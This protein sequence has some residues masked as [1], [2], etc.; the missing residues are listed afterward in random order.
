MY[1]HVIQYTVGPAY[2]IT[3]WPIFKASFSFHKI[4]PKT[5][6]LPYILICHCT[7]LPPWFIILDKN[8]FV[9]VSHH[10][11]IPIW[12]AMYGM[13]E[14]RYEESFF[15][16]KYSRRLKRDPQ[17]FIFPYKQISGR[18]GDHKWCRM[19]NAFILC[20]LLWVS[21]KSNSEQR[22]WQ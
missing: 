18:N 16:R 14:W 2:Q 15:L 11:W 8:N 20:D 22:T 1:Y 4:T 7:S 19:T 17:K 5:L 9:K 13:L 21:E 3:L 12:A 6:K 10:Y